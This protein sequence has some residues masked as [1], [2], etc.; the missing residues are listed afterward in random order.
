MPDATHGIK[1]SHFSSTS[2]LQPLALPVAE[3]VDDRR[4]SLMLRVPRPMGRS[5]MPPVLFRIWLLRTLLFALPLLAIAIWDSLE[6]GFVAFAACVCVLALV[7]AASYVSFLVLKAVL[8]W[9]EQ[10]PVDC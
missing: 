7:T 1:L 4:L 10:P 3:N 6:E 9:E 8:N 2:G 5:H